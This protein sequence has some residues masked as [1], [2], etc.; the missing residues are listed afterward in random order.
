M[1]TP[2]HY[3]DWAL[4]AGAS[5]GVGASFAHKLARAGFNLVLVARRT[6][7]LTNLSQKIRAQNGIEVRTLSLDLKASDVLERIRMVTDDVEIGVLIFNASDLD[8]MR[9]SFVDR[10]LDNILASVRVTVVS[11]TVLVHHFGSR[12][13]ARGRGGIILVGSLSGNAGMP[14]QATYCA[15]KAYTQILAE[16]LWCELRGRGVDVLSLVL[17]S[18][19]TPARKRNG[20]PHVPGFPVLSSDD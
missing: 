16:S 13:A 1:I 14:L 18:T 17:G 19:D 5:E 3:G 20:I 2:K 6:E 10:A 15:A 4:I 9:G 11:Q 7:L 8:T 12:M